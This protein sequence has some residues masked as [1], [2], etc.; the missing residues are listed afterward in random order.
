VIGADLF[1]PA[2]RAPVQQ[3]VGVAGVCVTLRDITGAARDYPIGYG[4]AA[5]LAE[6]VHHFQ[7]AVAVAGAQVAGNE[8]MSG[9]GV[10]R[11]Q[12]PL[13]QIYHVYVI[14]NTGAVGRVVVVAINAQLI[15]L[16]GGYLG[17]IRH[18]VVGDPLRVFADQSAFVGAG[19]IEVAQYRN[20]PIGFGAVQVAQHVFNVELAGTVG[21]GGAER[22]VFANGHAGRVAVYGGRGAEYDTVGPGSLHGL[23]QAQ[24][25]NDVVVVVGERLGHR[26]AHGLEAGKVDHRIEAL[27]G[28]E[29][30]QQ[31]AV[32]DVALTPGYGTAGD[33][34]YALYCLVRAI[35]EIV[36][37]RDIV[38]RLQQEYA[39]VATDVSGAAGYEQL[40]FSGFSFG[41]FGLRGPACGGTTIRFKPPSIGR[42]RASSYRRTLRVTQSAQTTNVWPRTL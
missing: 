19:R 22:E 37:H 15:E 12:V 21:V 5:G 41:K 23:Q 4:P 40:H 2:C 29:V 17:N 26:L 16:A 28:K 42:L 6:C 14:S 7:H 9:Q 18:Q 33:G 11:L 31:G 25:A 13:G 27:R 3:C 8:A 10:Q 36:E 30:V 20:V 32:T 38:P 24:A 1:Q 34:L 35:A 39:G